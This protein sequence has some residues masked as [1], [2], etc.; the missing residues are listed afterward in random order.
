MVMVPP[1]PPC[2]CGLGLFHLSDGCDDNHNGEIEF[3]PHP[4]WVLVWAMKS[5]RMIFSQ[6][7]IR[8]SQAISSIVTG[9]QAHCADLRLQIQAQTAD[10]TSI[11]GLSGWLAWV[12]DC[13]Q[14]A[15]A[16]ASEV[17]LARRL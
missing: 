12:A 3:A 14:S 17:E 11:A 9:A 10:A 8:T 7:S 5:A 1:L 13:N 6:Y 4:L 16:V 2:G 15:G